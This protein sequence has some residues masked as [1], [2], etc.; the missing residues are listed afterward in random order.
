M[1]ATSN[2][3]DQPTRKKPVPPPQPKPDDYYAQQEQKRLE[4]IRQR[5]QDIIESRHAKYR[6]SP[7]QKHKI[8]EREQNERKILNEQREEIKRAQAEREKK[9]DESIRRY[10]QEQA[11]RSSEEERKRQETLN[12]NSL[13]NKELNRSLRE[14]RQMK[15]N[16]DRMIPDVSPAFFDKFETSA[17]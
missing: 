12:R 17:R 2:L 8:Q 11:I 10:Q 1:F 15:I 6:G 5:N 14:E 3:I 9:E 7:E 13:Q 16:Q 4:S